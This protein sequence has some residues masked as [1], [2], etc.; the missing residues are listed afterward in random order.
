LPQLDQGESVSLARLDSWIVYSLVVFLGPFH[1][2]LLSRIRPSIYF[3]VTTVLGAF[4]V[5]A[6]AWVQNVEQ[7]LVLRALLVTT[8]AGLNPGFFFLISSWYRPDEM[9][10]RIGIYTSVSFI[11]VTP[12]RMAI[13]QMALRFDMALGLPGWRW[14]IMLMSLITL[15]VGLLAFFLLPDMPGSCRRLM[16]QERKISIRRLNAVGAV[17]GAS[18]A[19][20]GGVTRRRWAMELAIRDRRVW[21][22]SFGL[23]VSP[24]ML[25]YNNSLACICPL[26]PVCRSL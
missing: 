14:E 16:G 20:P 11:V 3:S 17:I 12:G 5:F 19:N 22:I 18:D 23:L 21:I 26:T 9:G 24:S 13:K 8:Q 25:T 7:L 4:A 1:N 6:M 2:I 15:V 10:K